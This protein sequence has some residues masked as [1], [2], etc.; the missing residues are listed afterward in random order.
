[1]LFE[2]KKGGVCDK[3]SAS[4]QNAF[5]AVPL[6]WEWSSRIG[7]ILP[8]R[9]KLPRAPSTG[10]ED[11]G[12]LRTHRVARAKT[13]GRKGTSGFIDGPGNLLSWTTVRSTCMVSFYSVNSQNLN[14]VIPSF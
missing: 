7:P 3:N 8:S 10:V 11:S 13:N 14:L 2:I 4:R 1:M 5:G 9:S 12:S 6:V